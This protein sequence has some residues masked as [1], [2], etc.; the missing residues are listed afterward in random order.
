MSRTKYGAAVVLLVA[1]WWWL[2]SGEAISQEMT[3]VI[4]RNFPETQQV[5]GT[6]EIRGPIQNATLI[7]RTGIIVPPVEREETTRLVHAGTIDASGYPHLVL[8]LAGQ[9]KG[10]VVGR[11]TVGAVLLPA[12]ETVRLAFDERGQMMFAFEAVAEIGGS[13]PYFESTQPRFDLGFPR[14]DV[15]LYNNG[16]R[17]IEVDLFAYLT[18]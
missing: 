4:V 3:E 10:E 9:T 12:E 1:V 18:N 14:Y 17:S 7:R 11:A 5:D 6:V 8:S 16:K 2:P 13:S 15:Y